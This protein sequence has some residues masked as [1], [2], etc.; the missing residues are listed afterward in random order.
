MHVQTDTEYRKEW[1]KTA[2]ALDVIDSD[3]VHK[4]KSHIIYWEMLWPVSR[5]SIKYPEIIGLSYKFTIFI[6]RNCLPIVIMYS[7]VATLWIHHVN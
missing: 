7:I 6:H 4:G 3:P 5:S 1:D 2:V